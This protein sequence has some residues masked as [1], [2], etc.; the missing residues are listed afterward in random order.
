MPVS[1]YK[2]SYFEHKHERE[3]FGAF[4]QEMLDRFQETDHQIKVVFEFEAD[5]ASID[6][7]ILTKRGIIIADLKELM[8]ADQEHT[9]N[10]IISGQENGNWKYTISDGREFNLG[11]YGSKN[12]YMQLKD[13][14]Y[15]FAEWME[16]H[17]KSIFGRGLSKGDALRRIDCYAVISPGFNQANLDLPWE[18]IGKWFEVISLTDFAYRTGTHTNANVDLS[19]EK[20][21]SIIIALGVQKCENLREFLPKYIPPKEP[22]FFFSSPPVTRLFIDREKEKEKLLENL[23]APHISVIII[24]GPI[25]IGK[26]YIAALLGEISKES[27]RKIYWVDCDNR[28][29]TLDSFITAITYDIGNKNYLALLSDDNTSTEDKIEIIVS[30][31]NSR[32]CLLIFDDFQKVNDVDGMN[33]LLSCIS[34]KAPNVSVIITTSKRPSCL[35]IPDIPIGSIVEYKLKGFQFEA[36]RELVNAFDT[37][38]TIDLKAIEEIHKRSS[39]NPHGI[40]LLLYLLRSEGWNKGISELPF[41]DADSCKEWFAEILEAIGD[42][43]VELMKRLCVIQNEIPMD[44]IYKMSRSSDADT[45][46]LVRELVNSNVLRENRYGA[47]SHFAYVRDYLYRNL[48]EKEK[49]KS[50]FSAGNFFRT[51]S[52]RFSNPRDKIESQIQAIMHFSESG[53][54]EAWENVL[55]ISQEADTELEEIGDHRRALS[56]AD[57]GIVAS[58]ELND[59]ASLLTWLIRAMNL[60]I[61]IWDLAKIPGRIDS[62]EEIF[63]DEQILLKG[64][65]ESDI[66]GIKN[67]KSRYYIARGKYEQRQDNDHQALEYL[68]MGLAI[69]KELND[70]RLICECLFTSGQFYKFKQNYELAQQNYEEALN[71]ARLAGDKLFEH[72]C[73]SHLGMIERDMGNYEKAKELFSQALSIS[74]EEGHSLGQRINQ[75]HLASLSSKL[76]GS[77]ESEEYFR[78]QVN[79]SR[80]LGLGR[81]LRV[82]LSYLAEAL[83]ESR[84]YE[85]AEE[86]VKEYINESQNAKDGIGIAWG[87]YW[88]GKLEKR[89]GN[90]QTGNKLIKMGMDKAKE[91]NRSDY[92]AEFEKELLEI[93]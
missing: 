2:G 87:F 47:F 44:M 21:E 28:D 61:K 31:M 10:V 27:G 32:N 7:L 70:D 46:R 20:Q 69:A 93:N 53:S 59:H 66:A 92:Y 68:E 35:D 64:R 49:S 72:K 19:S 81:G 30:Y 63:Q 34:R 57:S 12:P 26:T 77:K 38:T 1:V 74:S 86:V 13:H 50:H 88:K 42:S 85:D 80:E 3:A 67:Q 4:L 6:L 54:P 73:L 78:E 24:S 60:E 29:V 36:T 52:D 8:K 48:S 75:N 16:N 83:I 43:E 40:K 76:G 37:S 62:I 79:S 11:S 9:D 23:K 45:D 90:I 56:V 5:T 33:R 84:K 25:G 89:K 58:G 39:G 18:R 65:N 55:Q 51:H 17:S 15:R 41:F 14:R 22:I 91:I 82:A 71:Y